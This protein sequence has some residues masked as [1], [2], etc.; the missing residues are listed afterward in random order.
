VSST[1]DIV[2][3]REVAGYAPDDRCSLA[4]VFFEPQFEDIAKSLAVRPLTA[5]YSDEPDSVANSIDDPIE[6]ERL[7][8]QLLPA[9]YFSP[10]D[11]L[12][13][14]R[15]IAGQLGKTPL[16]M[17]RPVRNLA[18]DLVAELAEVEK[19]LQQAEQQGAKFYFV[20]GL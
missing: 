14:V 20:I 2:F 6:R 16:Q 10:T 3:D 4:Y 12:V 5:F 17:D 7:R 15:A 19:A 18:Q 1:I 13:S 11:G 8:K 9:Q